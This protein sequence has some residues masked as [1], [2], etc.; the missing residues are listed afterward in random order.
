MKIMTMSEIDEDYGENPSPSPAYNPFK[1]SNINDK[2]LTQKI[3][4]SRDLSQADHIPIHERLHEDAKVKD[5]KYRE[6]EHIKKEE[7][8]YECTFKPEISRS[9]P[10]GRYKINRFEEL[11]LPNKNAKEEIYKMRRESKEIEGCTFQ[12]NISYSKISIKNSTIES[13]KSVFDKLYEENESKK[14]YL[15]NLEIENMNKQGL[16][17]THS[18]INNSFGSM[19][20]KSNNTQVF[21]R[22]YSEHQDLKMKRVRM[23]MDKKAEEENK[24][25]FKPQRITKEKDRDFGYADS[26]EEEPRDQNQIYERLYKDA[27]IFNHRL[28][29]KQRQ[30]EI[31]RQNMSRFSSLSYRTSGKSIF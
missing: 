23:E 16:S 26:D 8:A 7:E 19:T 31:E 2:S 1:N 30:A 5:A 10:R 15:R 6:Y 4:I 20:P 14:K 9:V 22:L 25:S 11:A 27:E 3:E 29:Y 28:N 17:S 12:P 21:N 18:F 13:G 24:Y